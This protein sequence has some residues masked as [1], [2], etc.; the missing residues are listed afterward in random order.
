[1]KDG[2]LEFVDAPMFKRI[3]HEPDVCKEVIECVLGI[4]VE[5]IDYANTEQEGNAALGSRGVRFDVFVRD[6]NRTFDVEMQT[7][8]RTALGRRLRYYQS[9]LDTSILDEGQDYEQLDEN[10][11]IFLCTYDAF[12]YSEPVY[13][14]ERTCSEVPELKTHD[15]SHWVVLNA[16]AWSKDDDTNRSGLLEYIA[17]GVVNN[18][19]LVKKLASRVDLANEDREWRKSAMGL[20]TVDMDLRAQYSGGFRDGEDKLGKLVSLLLEENRVD[21]AKRAGNDPEYRETLYKEFGFS[22]DR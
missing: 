4:E 22:A 9:L 8:N 11:I 1:M 3:M 12:G 5:K 14:I 15:D 13:S 10:F 17:K 7:V 18:T 16:S 21:E 2:L 20:M 6:S 19:A